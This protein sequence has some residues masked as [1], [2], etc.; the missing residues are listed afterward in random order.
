MAAPYPAIAD[1]NTFF[2]HLRGAVNKLA[3]THLPLLADRSG[4]ERVL[5][6]RRALDLLPVAVN[7]V[8]LDT[9]GAEVSWREGRYAFV[10]HYDL[11][12]PRTPAVTDHG[13]IALTDFER[14]AEM[15]QSSFRVDPAS[16]NDLRVL[17]FSAQYGYPDILHVVRYDPRNELGRY[18]YDLYD[19]LGSSSISALFEM[20]YD[21]NSKYRLRP[22]AILN[23]HEL[24]N[25]EEVNSMFFPGDRDEAIRAAQEG[26]NSLLMIPSVP[27][28]V[29]KIFGTAKK[30][31][32]FGLFEYQFFTVSHHYAYLAIEAAIYHRWSQTQSKPFVLTHGQEQITVYDSGRGSVSHLC[33]KKN[34]SRREVKLNGKRF[35]FSMAS[36][37]ARLRQANIITEHQRY[38]LDNKLKLRNIHSHLEYGPL[39]MPNTGVLE[40]VAEAINALFDR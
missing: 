13:M 22:E 20:T 26:I 2:R 36:L 19:I 34:W 28:E 31:Y 4:P 6:I 17:Q 35:P 23:E 29:R 11:S 32:I 9:E 5:S 37:L 30:L 24:L 18:A 10:I 39:E 12:Q 33:E 14:H 27:E 21:F 16:L 40:T 7:V 8:T 38:A 1:W 3:V 25:I 15:F